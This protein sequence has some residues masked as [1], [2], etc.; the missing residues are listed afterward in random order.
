MEELRLQEQRQ[1][2][3]RPISTPQLKAKGSRGAPLLYHP[4]HSSHATA[5]IVFSTPACCPSTRLSH[6][7]ELGTRF[8]RG[9]VLRDNTGEGGRRHPLHS[10]PHPSLGAGPTGRLRTSS[11]PRITCFTRGPAKPSPET[12]CWWWRRCSFSSSSS[13]GR[14]P[15]TAAARS[16]GASSPR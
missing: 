9:C 5:N 16:R 2:T 12:G 15:L 6:A 10:P 3:R 13:S 4:N 7:H 14:R 1:P 8:V 11:A